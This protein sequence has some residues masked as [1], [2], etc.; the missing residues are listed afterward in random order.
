V[1][2]ADLLEITV[3]QAQLLGA[4]V[5]EAKAATL[6]PIPAQVVVAVQKLTPVYS[7]LAVA[8]VLALLLYVTQFKE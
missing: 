2:E 1:P 5:M 4:A 8:A 3:Q 6:V 7:V